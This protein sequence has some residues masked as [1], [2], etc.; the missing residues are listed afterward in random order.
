MAW[1]NLAE[2]TEDAMLGDVDF[3]GYKVYRSLYSTG[4]WQM[5]AAF[6]NVN[7]PVLVKNTEGEVINAKR[8]LDTQEVIAYGEPGYSTLEN[9]EYVKVDLPA[10]THVYDD[11]GG[12]FLG[13]ELPRPINGL[14]YFYAIVAYDPYK[15][16][17]GQSPELLSQ[18]SAKSNYMKDPESGAPLPVIPTKLYT[19]QVVSGLEL[20][21]I[22]VVPNPY[23]GTALFESRYEDKIRFTNL[24]PACKISI[25]TIT[26]DLVDTIY[27]NDGTDAELWSLISRN[28][29]KAV[30]GL[31]IY[32]VE[33]EQP[34]Y[35]KFTGKFV[36]I[37]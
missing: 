6:D 11:L 25:F 35:E 26:G 14:K 1:D 10:V 23:R 20:S 30:S 27:H 2:T 22:K 21:R 7:A 37:R 31:Y 16:P 15:P 33:T 18:E 28:T 4:N 19:E 24:P 3:E 9:F 8:N 36:I 13:R 32:I 17:R 5:V 34:S 12:A 29:Q